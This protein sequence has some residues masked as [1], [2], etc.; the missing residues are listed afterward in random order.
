[1]EHVTVEQRWW[2]RG[3][4]DCGA[5]E[6]SIIYELNRDDGTVDHVIVEQCHIDVGT[7]ELPLVEELN[8]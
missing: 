4:S 5:V 1:M 7:I 2:N 8:I 6:H 3:T